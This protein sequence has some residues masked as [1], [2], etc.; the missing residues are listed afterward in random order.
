VCVCA[1]RT[2]KVCWGILCVKV[3]QLFSEGMLRP[4]ALAWGHGKGH[5]KFEAFDMSLPFVCVCAV[6]TC[7][8]CWRILYVNKV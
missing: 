4:W 3:M 2:C 1:V 7:K 5:P 8:V 6:L